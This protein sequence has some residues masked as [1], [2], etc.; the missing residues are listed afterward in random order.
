MTFPI[1]RRNQRAL[2][3]AYQGLV[4]TCDIDRTY[5]ATRFSSLEGLARIPF[6]F[7]IDKT[8]IAGMA[9]LLREVRRGPAEMSAHT[10]LYFVSASPAQL[11]P[12]VERKMLLDGLEFDGTTFK[13]WSKVLWSGR[14]GRLKEQ[15]GYK[16]TAL[17]VARQELP[18]AAA[19]ILFGD[20]LE[21]DALAFC[22]YA[23]LL[24]GRIPAERRAAVL[25]SLGVAPQDAAAAAALRASFACEGGVRRIYIRLERGDPQSFAAFGPGVR[26]CRGPFQMA[27]GL[28]DDGAISLAGLGRVVADL[29]QH[30]S[31]SLELGERLLDAAQR[32]LIAWPLAAQVAE[33]LRD[34][35]GAAAL[36]DPLP[37]E[38]SGA[39]RPQSER[40]RP[41]LP[42]H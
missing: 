34:E 39:G 7:G 40:G 3:A 36:P 41:W 18:V 17:L 9:R 30:S 42:A 20:D 19:E 2:P 14:W 10:P 4:V 37:A 11:R 22:C 31:E 16:V 29:A 38:A 35:L 5:L 15:V 13:D 25:E 21:T 24:A 27:L 33:T 6:E 26:A 1:N 28:F 32:G 12:V 8:D 23:D